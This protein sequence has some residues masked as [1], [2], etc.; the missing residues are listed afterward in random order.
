[1]S[2]FHAALQQGRAPSGVTPQLLQQ[3]FLQDVIGRVPTVEGI[4]EA[5][6]ISGKFPDSP[7][8]ALA[9]AILANDELWS[10]RPSGL[11][12][13]QEAVRLAR[14]S[15]SPIALVYALIA[16]VKAQVL[17]GDSSGLADAREAQIAAEAGNI[18]GFVW[19][20]G[21]AAN[22]LD[23]S[24]ASRDVVEHMRRSRAEM[25]SLGAPH[26]YVAQT[27]AYE[28]FGLLLLGHWRGCRERLR[29]TLGSTP[30]P[31]ADMI[32]RL[33]AALLA[34]W[35][36]RWAEADGHLVRAEELFA[37]RS[38]LRGHGLDAVRAELALA[39]D[40]T[41]QAVAIALAGVENHG[42]ANMVE[43]LIPLAAKA[44]AN[45]ARTSLDRSKD[46]SPTMARLDDL[47]NQHPTVVADTGPGPMHRA[48]VR[49]MQAWYDAEIQRGQDDPAAGTAWQYAAQACADGQL[50]WDEAYTWWE[51]LRR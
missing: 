2:C 47:R 13:A 14:A 10:G 27:S 12:R 30:G 29:V 1:L 33:T 32:A 7:Q 34:T 42:H 15:R 50:A 25:V 24:A 6:R 20:V 17:A 22:C 18:P 11:A 9:V 23:A 16:K 44:I 37:A 41:E 3:D 4:S 38:I 26:C 21:W 46:P 19:A 28:A 40:D 31:R 39:T 8:Y 49:A 48:Q 35:Q 51:P 36:G 45:E 5:V 43:R